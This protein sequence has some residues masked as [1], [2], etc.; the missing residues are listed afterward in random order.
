MKHNMRIKI[1]PGQH[2]RQ[3]SNVLCEQ[4]EN[5]FKVLNKIRFFSF[6]LF[7]KRKFVPLNEKLKV[8]FPYISNDFKLT[9]LFEILKMVNGK[10]HNIYVHSYKCTEIQR[11][12]EVRTANSEENILN[13]IIK[14]SPKTIIEGIIHCVKYRFCCCSNFDIYL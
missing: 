13:R 14:M 8:K 2:C 3:A 7:L 6:C 11:T 12:I 10:F 9:F 4:L 1:F 5:N